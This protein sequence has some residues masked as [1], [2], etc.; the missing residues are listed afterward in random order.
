MQACQHYYFG[1]FYLT[2]GDLGIEKAVT[3]IWYSIQLSEAT[4]KYLRTSLE[5]LI[6]FTSVQNLHSKT[7]GLITIDQMQFEQLQEV[8][9]TWLSLRV[10]GTNWI[11]KQRKEVMNTDIK[12]LVQNS[13]YIQNVPVEHTSAAK[14]WIDDGVFKRTEAPTFAENPTL[15]GANVASRYTPFSYAIAGGEYPFSGWD[16]VHVKKFKSSN[17]LVT[18]YGEYIECILRNFMKKLSKQQVSF[19]IAL[20]DCM[21][22]KQHVEMGTAYDRI[23]TSNLMDYIL[24]PTLLKL[25]S[26]ILNHDNHLATI[27]TETIVWTL[28]IMPE[29][30][31]SLLANKLQIPKLAKMAFEDSKERR[32][33]ITEYLD[34]SSEFLNYLRA[35]FYA[36]RLKR[37]AEN[38]ST[39]QKPTIPVIKELG[40]EFQLRLRDGIRNENRIVFFRSAIN[41]RRVTRVA[42][43]ER[44][45]EWVPLQKK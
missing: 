5:D 17:C 16:Y 8:W 37:M 7:T 12:F 43:M 38:G 4:Y 42:G 45:L 13:E 14:K 28:E 26:R 33:V 9:K 25:C 40:N 31:F 27:M 11:Q 32:V 3:E 20:C 6:S 15:T 24:L 35:M 30:G 41:R 44:Y 18:M 22:I 36:H 39:N 2:L 10:Q 19:H 29:A 34:N 1:F 23:L 21:N